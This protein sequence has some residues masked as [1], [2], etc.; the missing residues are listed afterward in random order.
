MLKKEYTE[1]ELIEIM[2][3]L[4]LTSRIMIGQYNVIFYILDLDLDYEEKIFYSHRHSFIPT[5]RDKSI[6]MSLGIWNKN[7]PELAVKSFDIKQILRYQQAYHYRYEGDNTTS[8]NIPFIHGEWN[9]SS[10]DSM[11]IKKIVNSFNYQDM[12]PKNIY[13]PWISCP[14]VIEKFE[15]DKR[16]VCLSEVALEVIEKAL[17]VYQLINEYEFTLAFKE[18]YP[19]VTGYEDDF[20]SIT[21]YLVGTK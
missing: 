9:I 7:T 5:F 1:K 8:F 12:Y 16:I 11:Y 17:K 6:H 15:G 13:H 20:D 4:D 14:V 10:V 18:L 3:A 2:D 19:N 21:K